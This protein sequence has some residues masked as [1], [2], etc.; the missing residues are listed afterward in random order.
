MF[1]AQIDMRKG[2]PFL[3]SEKKNE[4]LLPPDEHYGS[5]MRRND[6]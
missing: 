4:D 3:V 1:Y 2:L 5:V 6:E